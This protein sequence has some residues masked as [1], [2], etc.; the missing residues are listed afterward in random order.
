MASVFLKA[1]GR[2]DV[3][4]ETEICLRAYRVTPQSHAYVLNDHDAIAWVGPEDA[5]RL[6][7]APADVP[8]LSRIWPLLKLEG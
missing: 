4:E 1:V 7:I 3:Q 2:G 5:E 8:L 6:K